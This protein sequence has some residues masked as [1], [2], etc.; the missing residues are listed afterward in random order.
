VNQIISSSDALTGVPIQQNF[1]SSRPTAP[2][3]MSDRRGDEE[4]ETS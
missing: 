3:E 1:P 4:G 2:G